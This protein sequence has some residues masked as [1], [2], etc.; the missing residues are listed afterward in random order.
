MLAALPLVLAAVGYYGDQLRGAPLPSPAGDAVLYRYQLARAA[1][2]GGRWWQ[3]AGD[4]RL[5]RPYP[6]EIAK[7]PGLYEGVDLMLLNAAVGRALGPA[8]TYHLAV[9]A[10]LAANGWAAAWI[11]M[12][13]TRSMLWAAV[14]VTLITLNQSVAVR[15]TGHLH[16]FKFGWVLL[17]VWAFARFLE[18]PN[19]RRALLLG[20]S[21]ALLLQGSFYL[22]FFTL[23]GV[24]FWFMALAWYGRIHRDHYRSAIVAVALFALIGGVLVLPVWIGSSAVVATDVYFQR[25]WGETWSYGSELWK[26]VVPQGTEL[27]RRYYKEVHHRETLPVMDEGWNFP[28]YT[29]VLGVL[30]AGLWDRRRAAVPARLHGFVAVSLGLVGCWTVLSL[31]GGP[32]ALLYYIIPSFR[33][34]GRAGLLVVGLG[35]VVA[36][37]VLAE[38]VR[39]R[40]SRAA[41]AALSLGVLSLVIADAHRAASGFPGWATGAA[42]PAWVEWLRNQPPDVRL[43]AFAPLAGN[44]FAS[45]GSAALQWLPLHGHA[46]LNGCDFA[47][48]E[49]D[50][51]LLG[52]TY[53]KPNPAGLRFVVSLGYEA[54]AFRRDYL[55][56][57]PWIATLPWLERVGERSDWLICR[58]R[59]EA[60]RPRSHTLDEVLAMGRDDDPPRQVPGGSCITGSWPVEDD[61]IV[62][63]SDH[64]LLAW[65]DDRGRIVSP[66]R[67][68]FY[69]HVFGP[70]IPAYCMRTPDR[71]GFYRLLVLDRQ[72][73]RRVSIG[74]RVVARLPVAIDTF[75]AERPK[76]TAHPVVIPPARQGRRADAVCLMLANASDRYAQS[77]VFREHV[78]GAAQ[79]HPGLRSSWPRADAGALILRVAPL[80]GGPIESGNEREI[81]LPRDLQAGGQLRMALSDD[82]IP[83]SWSDLPLRVELSFKDVGAVEAPLASADLKISAVE[84]AAR[85]AGSHSAD[86]P[87]TR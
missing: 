10:A 11:V 71:P 59:P 87:A 21:A 56:K 26:Y 81:P 18:R 69:Q 72:L 23:A 57:N 25:G 51:R 20:L 74:Y 47:L 48:F 78:R 14:A 44:P 77:V 86:E 62:S 9:L 46:T 33:C 75:P 43:A 66:P 68:A 58:A 3:V 30:A 38:L 8:A 27:A 45:W 15:I 24:G 17:L 40:R 53:E 16:L 52:A 32:A 19:W 35:S 6:T 67:P 49:G 64:A 2:L 29:I 28:G 83:P 31:S 80:G 54:L 37:V 5:G 13:L 79:T 55:A 60:P 1:E 65:C 39:T 4:G 36:P 12:R 41:R 85:V 22:G 76:I 61:L 82:R 34:Y 7:H 63:G 42:A 73:R 50:L 70:G 84:T